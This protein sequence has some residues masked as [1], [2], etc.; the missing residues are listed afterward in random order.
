MER[1]IQV[2]TLENLSPEAQ[3]PLEVPAL[4]S[5]T[6]LLWQLGPYE[7]GLLQTKG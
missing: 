7:A 6:L 5:S 4:S 3:E 2:Q 1:E